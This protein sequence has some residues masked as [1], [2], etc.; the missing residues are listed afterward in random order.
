MLGCE[1]VLS[2][3]I[4]EEAFTVLACTTLALALLVAVILF[5]EMLALTLTLILKLA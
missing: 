2:V 4:I 3:P 5:V 1:L